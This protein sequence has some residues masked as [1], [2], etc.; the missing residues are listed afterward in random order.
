MRKLLGLALTMIAVAGCADARKPAP[1]YSTEGTTSVRVGVVN[2]VLPPAEAGAPPR[3]LLRYDDG[4]SATIATSQA[5]AFLAGD[6]VRVV[7]R[8]NAID[9]EKFGP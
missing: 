8:R 2:A 4:G 1:V 3:L 5:H 9:I 7:T 6:R